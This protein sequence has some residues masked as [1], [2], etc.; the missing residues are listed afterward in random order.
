MIMYRLCWNERGLHRP[1]RPLSFSYSWFVDIYHVYYFSKYPG[2][3]SCMCNVISRGDPRLL[4]RVIRS[5]TRL[6]SEE[7]KMLG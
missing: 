6:L 4:S 1:H 5:E 3:A 7:L 2:Y